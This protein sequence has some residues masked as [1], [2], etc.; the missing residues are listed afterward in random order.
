MRGMSVFHQYIVALAL[1]LWREHLPGAHVDVDRGGGESF[2]RALCKY[3]SKSFRDGDG[4][5]LLKRVRTVNSRSSN[6]MQLT[7]MICGAVAR[8]FERNVDEF[9]KLVQKREMEIALRP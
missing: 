7:D 8:S 4:K 1:D 9:R 2:S 3:V 6:L 5:P